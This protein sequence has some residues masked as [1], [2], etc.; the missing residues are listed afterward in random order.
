ME[1]RSILRH[2][3]KFAEVHIHRDVH[4]EELRSEFPDFENVIIQ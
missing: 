2:V 4:V 1:I 3:G